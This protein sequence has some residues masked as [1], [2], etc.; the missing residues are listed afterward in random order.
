MDNLLVF[1]TSC[2]KIKSELID[3]CNNI[4]DYNSLHNFGYF[5]LLPKEIFDY[6]L[7]MTFTDNNNIMFMTNLYSCLYNI[8]EQLLTTITKKYSGKYALK[9]YTYNHNIEEIIACYIVD[10]P[11]EAGNMKPS[12]D[13]DADSTG[14]L[15]TFVKYNLKECKN[16]EMISEL[17]MHGKWIKK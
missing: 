15:D 1:N 2:L 4:A 9:Y 8:N 12:L 5:R 13:F 3:L 10:T 6:I 16:I 14:W 7:S 11:Y 17:L